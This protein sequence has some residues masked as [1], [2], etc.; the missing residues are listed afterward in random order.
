MAQKWK[1]KLKH[2]VAL[3]AQGFVF[4]VVLFWSTAPSDSAEAASQPAAAHAIR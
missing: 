3:A 1:A 4:G 2:P